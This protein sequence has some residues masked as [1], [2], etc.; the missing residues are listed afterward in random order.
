MGAEVLD[1]GLVPIL[2]PEVS[3]TASDKAEAEALLRDTL[4]SELDRLPDDRQVMLKLTLPETSNLYAPVIAHP[5]VMRVVALSGGYDRNEATRRLAQNIGMIASFSR[6]LTEGLTA[7]QT[8]AEFNAALATA[9]DEI[10]A[11]SI[12]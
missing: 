10:K 12:T 11:A 1:H 6:A 5:R 3:I 4:L 7:Q 9:I 2:E 8:D